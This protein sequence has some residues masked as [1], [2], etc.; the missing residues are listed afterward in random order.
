MACLLYENFL[1]DAEQY[2]DA[3]QL[4]SRAFHELL[5]RAGQAGAWQIPWMSTTFANGD[6][7]RDGNPIFSAVC[8]SR[9]LG[10][11]IIQHREQSG[12]ASL[13]V[14]IDTF[15]EGEP[16]ETRELVIT[17]VLSKETLQQACEL[18]EQWV[19][20]GRIRPGATSSIGAGG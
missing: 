16:E 7:I 14:W 8:N 20:H 18:M 9:R 5:T 3:E 17:C 15:A 13:H 4:W 11:R 2:R 19:C 12:N 6:P 10:I 1:E